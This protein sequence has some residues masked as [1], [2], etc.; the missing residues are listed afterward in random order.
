MGDLSLVGGRYCPLPDVSFAPHLYYTS[1][2]EQVSVFV[3][4]HG[5]RMSDDFRRR[6]RGNAVALVRVGGDVV[7][8]VSE[9]DEAVGSFVSRLRTSVAALGRPGVRVVRPR[10][11]RVLVLGLAPAPPCPR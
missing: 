5:V 4:P 10:V 3:V 2:D 6:V 1:D 8:V 9:D 7:G 11:P